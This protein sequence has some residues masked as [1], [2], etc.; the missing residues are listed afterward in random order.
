MLTIQKA[1]ATPNLLKYLV[2]ADGEGGS[3]VL[4]RETLL[5][6][7]IRG[8]LRVFIERAVKLRDAEDACERLLCNPATRVFVTPRTLARVAVDAVVEGSMAAIGLRVEAEPD[9][10][11]IVVIEFRHTLTA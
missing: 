2:Q 9:A 11:A 1:G 7:V 10:S 8:P 4:D 6:D 5:R 3:L